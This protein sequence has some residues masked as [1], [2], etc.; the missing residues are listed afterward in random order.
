MPNPF[1]LLVSVRNWHELIF[2]FA[3]VNLK[4][5]H[6]QRYLRAAWAVINPLLTMAVFTV[7]FS[8]VAAI[9]SEGVPY[10]L[11]AFCAI[12]PWIFFSSS[13]GFAVSCLNSNFNLI[14]RINFPKIT[15][16]LGSILATFFDFLISSALLAAMFALYGHPIGINALYA[17]P[18]FM[19]HMML[20]VGV[21]LMVSVLNVYFR[22]IQS[23]MPVILQ[24]WMLASPVG[25]PV[26]MV[27]K[28]L[29]PYYFL[30][31]MAGILDGCRK[32]LLHNHT[33]DPLS[34]NIAAAISIA[35]FLLGYRV[36]KMSEK[37]IADIITP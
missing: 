16:P 5:R 27:G 33:P 25:Y 6:K 14:T 22:D 3:L 32:A 7:V 12:V 34:F 23:A 36:F 4:Q 13:V 8:K 28:G 1:S 30:N 26:G 31:P 18:V 9:Q 24:V 17:I 2:A 15:V 19:V 21:C 29:L 10:P 11:F 37:N 20:T 35:V